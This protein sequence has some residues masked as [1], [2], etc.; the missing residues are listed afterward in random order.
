MLCRLT[1]YHVN[2]SSQM[3]VESSAMRSRLREIRIKWL[4]Y[5]IGVESDSMKII[6]SLKTSSLSLS[7]KLSS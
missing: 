3:F 1:P 6:S 5:S 4:D 7:P 2:N